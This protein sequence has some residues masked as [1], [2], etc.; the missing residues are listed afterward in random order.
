MTGT[1]LEIYQTL[2]SQAWLLFTSW[3]IPGTR[4]TP[5]ALGIFCLAFVMILRRIKANMTDGG[6]E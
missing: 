2:F 3:H 5:A 1:A 4:M 6:D